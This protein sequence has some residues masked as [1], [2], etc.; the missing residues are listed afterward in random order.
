MM[1][2]K[3][4]IYGEFH[5]DRDILT[6]LGPWRDSILGVMPSRECSFTVVTNQP[7]HTAANVKRVPLRDRVSLL[8]SM[9]TVENGV[10][11]VALHKDFRLRKTPCVESKGCVWSC[12]QRAPDFLIKEQQVNKEEITSGLHDWVL[13][14]VMSDRHRETLGAVVRSYRLHTSVGKAEPTLGWVPFFC[15]VVS[16]AILKTMN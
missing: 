10:L 16:G 8:E 1:R 6:R 2:D 7:L 13:C 5:T 15:S 14:F 11:V 9:M 12:M 4:S 3:A